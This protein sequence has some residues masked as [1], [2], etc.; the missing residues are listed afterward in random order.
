MQITA[1]FDPENRIVIT[2]VSALI[3]NVNI[4]LTVE[5]AL[6][7][8]QK[9]KCEYLLFDVREC[10]PGQT[11]TEAF[12]GM[13]DMRST[14][15]MGVTYRSAVVFNPENYPVERAMF[16]ENVVAN[17]PNP[18]LRMFTDINMAIEWLKSIQDR[19]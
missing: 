5:R 16:I 17:R 4:R 15:G 2:K 13:E 12:K 8:A 18:L 19:K 3:T 14:M 1:T 6:A 7:E 10:T 11:M 9:F